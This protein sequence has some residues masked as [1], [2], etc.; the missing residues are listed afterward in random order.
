MRLLKIYIKEILLITIILLQV[1]CSNKVALI[2]A[3]HTSVD[4]DDMEN[5]ITAFFDFSDEAAKA[6][7]KS[8]YAPV[9]DRIKSN[10]ALGAYEILPYKD[11]ASQ[12]DDVDRLISSMK[13]AK[14]VVVKYANDDLLYMHI[15]GRK[16]QSLLPISKGNVITG[17]W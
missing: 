15:S 9:F 13:P 4:S 8:I 2:E 14:I 16:I 10:K 6:N 1:S 7:L 5:T 3:F 11:A 12:W 17:W